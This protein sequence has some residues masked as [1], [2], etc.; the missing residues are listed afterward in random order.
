MAAASFVSVEMTFQ[1]LVAE[2]QHKNHKCSWSCTAMRGYVKQM[3][4][5]EMLAATTF[6]FHWR[7]I[8]MM[9]LR[10][11]LSFPNLSQMLVI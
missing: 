8:D 10:F 6:C 7:P 1:E 5:K 2:L 9:D 3:L 11:F 4:S